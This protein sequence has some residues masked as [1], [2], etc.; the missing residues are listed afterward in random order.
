MPNE[1]SAPEE[2]SA[3]CLRLAAGPSGDWLVSAGLYVHDRPGELA[4]L[5][6]AIASQ[7]AV[8]ES[9]HYNRSENPALVGICARVPAGQG[10]GH[11]AEA[12]HDAGRLG[13]A[14]ALL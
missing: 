13:P 14:P 8:I 3:G 10:V 11:L 5:C 6:S 12:L 7:G 2:L 9:F 4:D 1:P